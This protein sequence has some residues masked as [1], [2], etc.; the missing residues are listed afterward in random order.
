MLVLIVHAGKT[1]SEMPEQPW[2]EHTQH[3]KERLRHEDHDPAAR[4]HTGRRDE[5]GEGGTVVDP[6]LGHA[7]HPRQR[8]H[9]DRHERP[10]FLTWDCASS[11]RTARPI[12]DVAVFLSFKS[13][14][15]A[16]TSATLASSV[17]DD[18]FDY[19]VMNRAWRRQSSSEW[20]ARAVTDFCDKTQA[21]MTGCRRLRAHSDDEFRDAVEEAVALCA[22][23][24]LFAKYH[25]RAGCGGWAM[26]EESDDDEDGTPTHANLS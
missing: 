17:L 5:P 18:S 13:C 8:G 7:Q 21:W 2:L 22:R 14:T 6:S 24:E 4:G 19:V 10:C 23:D 3:V 15:Q 1:D 16:H 11:H 26:A 25:A 9:H 12:C 20:A